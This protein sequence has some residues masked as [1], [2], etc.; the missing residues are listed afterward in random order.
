MRMTHLWR[1][2]N[3]SIAIASGGLLIC[4]SIDARSEIREESRIQLGSCEM[5]QSFGDDFRFLSVEPS[6]YRDHGWI[7][8]TPWAGDFGDA[9][10]SDPGKD[11]PFRVVDGGLDI[12]AS[13]DPNGRWRS[14]LLASGDASGRG[15]GQTYGYFEMKAML[16]RGEGTWPAFWLMTLHPKGATD[17]SI[18][19][20]ALE[21]Y[22]S[23][24]SDFHSGYHVWTTLHDG[25]AAEHVTSVP[26]GS[27]YDAFHLFGVDVE[28]NYVTYYFD[29]K[30]T[31][32]VKTPPQH[33]KPLLILLNLAL[34]SG[35]PIVNTPNP[36]VMKVA[37]VKVFKRV[38]E[39]CGEP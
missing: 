38:T 27:L 10:F 19:I 28:L 13:K 9:V 37:Y 23:F 1:G 34:G 36:S 39:S 24:P 4:G 12:E 26:K 21:H 15:F 32:Q 22:G 33:K 35:W 7:A 16:P 29:R 14:G 17:P 5:T 6:T 8:H 30:R 18:E 31:W 2:A 11:S 20:D 25:A 3:R